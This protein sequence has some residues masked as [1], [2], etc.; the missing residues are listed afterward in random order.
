MNNH[1]IIFGV[2]GVAAVIIGICWLPLG[3]ATQS[4]PFTSMGAVFF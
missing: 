2:F 1:T 4:L 3:I